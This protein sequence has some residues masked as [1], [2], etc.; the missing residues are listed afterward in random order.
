MKCLTSGG[1]AAPPRCAQSLLSLAKRRPR[2]KP[3]E[4]TPPN[5]QCGS[6]MCSPRKRI[7]WGCSLELGIA[8]G[9]TKIGMA[10]L[11]Y[12]IKRFISLRKIVVA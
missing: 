6:S 4:A 7:G 11:V 2:A 5:T 12:N 9:T 8:R 10:N 3:W 1:S